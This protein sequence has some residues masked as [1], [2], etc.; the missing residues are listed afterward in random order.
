MY[1]ARPTVAPHF[2]TYRGDKKEQT[3]E[4]ITEWLSKWSNYFQIYHIPESDQISLSTM[5]LEGKAHTWWGELKKSP[6]VPTTWA[7]FSD[8]FTKRFTPAKDDFEHYRQFRGV[9]LGNQG[10]ESYV[11]DYM[12]ALAPVTA[13]GYTP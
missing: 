11:Q 3:Q 10:F 7:A 13:Q 9:Y 4:A 6:S 12:E 8:M 1:Q 2:G 5:Y